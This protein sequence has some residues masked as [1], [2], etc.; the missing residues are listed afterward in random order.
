MS[1]TQGLTQGQRIVIDLDFEGLMT[2]QE[3]SSIANQLMHSYS[4]NSRAAVPCHL[5]F[6]SVKVLKTV[7]ACCFRWKQTPSNSS[8]AVPCHLPF[9]SVKVLINFC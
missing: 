7:E 2:P 3:Q 4:A 9:T 5:H 1:L 6:T 8:A